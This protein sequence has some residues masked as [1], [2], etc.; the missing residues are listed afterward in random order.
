MSVAGDT[1]GFGCSGVLAREYVKDMKALITGSQGFVGKHLTEFL[2]RKG[3]EVIGL[4]REQDGVFSN[5][6]RSLQVV[7]GDIADAERVQIVLEEIRPD[8]IYNLAA[9]TSVPVSLRDPRITF[10]VNTGGILNIFEAVRRIG[11]TTRVL[12]VSSAQVY[13]SLP[14]SEVAF[15]ETSALNPNT[16]YSASKI[17]AETLA[18]SYVSAFGIDIV[19]VRPFNHIGPGQP[20]DFACSDFAWQ[21]AR[22]RRGIQSPVLHTGNL[23]AE[24]DFTD[25]RD[26]VE[27]Y[28]AALSKGV[29]GRI[30]NVCSGT[31]V[32]LRAI[33][34]SLCRLAGIP[35]QLKF[36][37]ERIR[38]SDNLRIC[39]NAARIKREL[40]WTPK[41][42]IETTLRDVLDYWTNAFSEKLQT[43]Q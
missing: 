34:E 28:W 29:T 25:V 10:C 8:Q 36:E 20:P 7:T 5:R 12:N 4:V 38:S 30:Y 17:M 32:S 2:L 39:G 22:I 43:L 42:P 9:I 41:I 23:N 11:L 33:V 6:S 18:E 27:A 1:K 40:G 14:S 15:S 21:I 16:T 24:R 31:A 37:S 35:V 19:T 13:G 26:V 3:V